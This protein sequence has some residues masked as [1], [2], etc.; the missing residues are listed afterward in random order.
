MIYALLLLALAI[1]VGPEEQPPA[2]G[3]KPL[4]IPS[5]QHPEQFGNNNMLDFWA[6]REHKP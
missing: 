3:D 6:N 4:D 1:A 5:L 2:E